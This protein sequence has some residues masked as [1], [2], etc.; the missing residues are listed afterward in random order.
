MID[1]RAA[2][3]AAAEKGDAFA[4][5][6]EVGRAA[7]VEDEF[8][9]H[10]IDI[11]GSVADTAKALAELASEMRT[12][13]EEGRLRDERVETARKTLAEETERRRSELADNTQEGDRRFSRRE[14]TMA[15]IFT[16]LVVIMVAIQVGLA[17]WG[18]HQAP[19]KTP[20]R[21]ALVQNFDAAR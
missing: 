2:T 20:S 1:E 4:R 5:G 15:L 9:R 17:L 21:T 14:R 18:H 6:K 13:R 12:M 10:F 16:G 3:E 7:Q 19:A 8:R 11:N